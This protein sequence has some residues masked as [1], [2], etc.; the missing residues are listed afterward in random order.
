MSCMNEHSDAGMRAVLTLRMDLRWL[1]SALCVPV[2]A[3]VKT[4]A[5]S[6]PATSPSQLARESQSRV[7]ASAGDIEAVLE[8]PQVRELGEKSRT[9]MILRVRD[10]Q[11]NL[12]FLPDT[13][14][15]QRVAWGMALAQRQA[16]LVHPPRAEPAAKAGTGSST[17]CRKSR[18]GSVDRSACAHE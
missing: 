2:F 4:R 8:R 15:K 7:T 17:S 9:E 3:S 16:N 6:S 11:N 10:A 18:L 5:Q 1:S 12:P 14:P 13:D